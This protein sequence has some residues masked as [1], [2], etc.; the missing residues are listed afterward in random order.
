VR[1]DAQLR[2]ARSPDDL[3][4]RRFSVIEETATLAT[5]GRHQIRRDAFLAVLRQRPSGAERL[6]VWVSEDAHQPELGHR[7]Y[8]TFDFA[9]NIFIA[10][11][12]GI[13]V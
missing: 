11:V 13:I 10:R 9:G 6:V 5:R 8:L 3:R 12:R 7:G 4:P 1:T 2:L